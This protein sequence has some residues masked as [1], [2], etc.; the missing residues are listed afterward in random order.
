MSNQ[1]IGGISRS[2]P[3]PETF[4]PLHPDVC[5]FLRITPEQGD[6]LAEKGV[7]PVSIVGGLIGMSQ[8]QLE[9]AQKN[10]TVQTAIVSIKRAAKRPQTDPR[11]T[12]VP[13]VKYTTAAEFAG[14]MSRGQ[15]SLQI[16]EQTV[17]AVLRRE[18]LVPATGP[19]GRE[20]WRRSDVMK[21]YRGGVAGMPP[22]HGHN[23][24][25]AEQ[26]QRDEQ[27]RES[28]AAEAR[29]RKSEEEMLEDARQREQERA[30][31]QRARV[32]LD[33]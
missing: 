12:R 8:F 26:K 7:L 20:Y 30:R 1:N 19:D 11:D 31:A 32:G 3:A 13:G 28:S 9:A 29:E 22:A 33:W 6:A 25:R 23:L 10:S 16:G 18:G 21:L 14:E 2:G 15:N 4:R 17:A 5:E 24:I 27:G